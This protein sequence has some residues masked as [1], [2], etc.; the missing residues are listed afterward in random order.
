MPNENTDTTADDVLHHDLKSIVVEY[1]DN[2]LNTPNKYQFNNK[3]NLFGNIDAL[4]AVEIAH[5][6]VWHIDIEETL[7]FAYDNP[8][9]RIKVE[10]KD[11]Y[12][13]RI[14]GTPLQIVAANNELSGAYGLVERLRPCFQN[15]EDFTE[16]LKEWFREGHRKETEKTMAPYVAAIKT[17]Y[18]V[19]MEA[20]I[21]N[22]CD[23]LTSQPA[24]DFRQ[25]LMPD[26]KH[27]VT[28]G[29]VF[30]L[31]IFHTFFGVWLAYTRDKSKNSTHTDAKMRMFDAIVYSSLIGRKTLRSPAMEHSFGTT[32]A[33]SRIRTAIADNVLRPPPRSVATAPS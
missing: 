3:L 5:N 17:F 32:G 12:G 8:A 25:A 10:I 7:Q 28:S 1:L 30:N 20:K 9:L 6:L 13:Q 29:F 19:W 15:P 22:D 18:G 23:F 4:N 31:H 33:L 21:P 14:F 11:P 27:V 26:P 16:Q 2:N 24:N